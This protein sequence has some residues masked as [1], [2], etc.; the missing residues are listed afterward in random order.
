M[1]H[2]EHDQPLLEYVRMAAFILPQSADFKLTEARKKRHICA[3]IMYITREKVI[4]STLVSA[5]FI[6]CM[7]I[8]GVILSGIHHFKVGSQLAAMNQVSNLS[9][10]L[11]RQQANLFSL[12]LVKSAS[13]DEI[14]E[15]LDTFTK[16]DFVIDATLYSPNGVMLAQSRH[17]LP[18]KPTLMSE[19]EPRSTQQIV[20]PIFTQ[21]DL[22]GF[23]RVTFD[24]EYGQTTR[25]KV[26]QLFH[27]LYGELIVL[28]FAGGLLASC[29]TVFR[30]KIAHPPHSPSKPLV[31]SS[32]T[33]T[34]RFHSRR[35]SWGKKV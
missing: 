23:L 30:R 22:I 11:V 10:L 9:H 6:C 25:S 28:F 12:M 2:M 13:A 17:A 3:E 21:Q 19:S 1:V 15:A 29:L 35:R 20:E 14:S 8:V 32:K 5:I 26:N 33:Q 24:A 16:E 31:H 7:A 4:K 18:F 34:Q 27:L